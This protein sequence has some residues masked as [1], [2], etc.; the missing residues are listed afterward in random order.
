MEKPSFVRHIY[1]IV[2]TKEQ[3]YKIGAVRDQE[4]AAGNLLGAKENI[5]HQSFVVHLFFIRGVLRILANTPSDP[6]L[7]YVVEI[8]GISED[9]AAHASLRFKRKDSVVDR[10]SQEIAIGRV[11]LQLKPLGFEP[12]LHWTAGI[13]GEIN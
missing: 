1:L 2:L 11:F 10:E 13:A 6:D 4:I 9:K 8:D 12:L 7:A 3:P 5:Q